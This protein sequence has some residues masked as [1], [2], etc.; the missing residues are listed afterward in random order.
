GANRALL[1]VVTGRAQFGL[2]GTTD[3]PLVGEGSGLD[4]L[5]D[6]H[7]HALRVTVEEGGAVRVDYWREGTPALEVT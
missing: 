3:T 7:L 5:R 1:R 4:D 6:V 2:L